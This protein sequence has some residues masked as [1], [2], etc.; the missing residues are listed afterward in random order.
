M[1]VNNK[2]FND[3][4]FELLRKG[5]NGS[6]KEMKYL[7]PTWSEI[8][9]IRQVR[10]LGIIMSND[11]SFVEHIYQVTATA[12]KYAGWILRTFTHSSST[13]EKMA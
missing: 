6:L 10:D 1:A 11:A 12:R 5:E 9:E 13:R 3:T 8:K 4:K 7:G 2:N